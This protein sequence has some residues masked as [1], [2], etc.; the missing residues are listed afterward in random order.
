MKEGIHPAYSEVKVT[1]TCGCSF[2]TGS[3]IGKDI[4][5]DVC[6]KCHPFYTGTQKVLDTSGR[7]DRFK[8]KYGKRGSAAGAAS[9]AAAS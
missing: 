3:T 2:T 6:S 8:S 1:C 7:I 9:G 4:H 5:I